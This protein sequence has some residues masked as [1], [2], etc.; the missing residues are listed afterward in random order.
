MQVE[1]VYNHGRLE[2]PKHLRLK[3]AVVNVVLILP[4]DEVL[5][6]PPGDP[7]QPTATAARAPDRSTKEASAQ[8]RTVRAA[9]DEILGPWKHQIHGGPPMPDDSFDRLRYQALEDK[10]LGRQ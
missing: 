4:D 3:H 6:D 2:L 9:I 1:A 10:H 5:A 8:G 7:D